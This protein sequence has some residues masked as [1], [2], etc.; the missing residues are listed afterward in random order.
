MMGIVV[1][2]C[3]WNVKFYEENEVDELEIVVTH[4]YICSNC[5]ERYTTADIMYL[6]PVDSG[7]LD[8]ELDYLDIIRKGWR[9]ERMRPGEMSMWRYS[10]LLPVEGSFKSHGILGSIGGT[11]LVYVSK[12]NSNIGERVW[13]K[14]DS[15]LP[16]GSL[17]DRA[18]AVVVSDAIKRGVD[19]IMTASTGNAGVALA[20]MAAAGGLS[21]V[22][23]VPAD[24][25]ASKIAQIVAYGA[26][27]VL[28]EGSYSDAYDVA[29][30]ASNELGIYCRN[31]G[32]NPFTIEGKKT[33]A[34]EICEQLS[35]I[36]ESSGEAIWKV[37]DVVIVPVG[38]GNIISGVYKGF[39]DLLAIGMVSRMPKIF[40]VQAE[41]SAAIANTYNSGD[42]VI[43]EVESNTI[44]D[45][46][47]ADRPA[48]GYRAINAVR[49]T[50]GQY[51]A[52]NDDA[53][54]M[55]VLELSSATGVFA[56]PSA[57]VSFAGLRLMQRCEWINPGDNVVM[58]ITG[59]GLKTV[60][61]CHVDTEGLSRIKPNLLELTD[62][63]KDK[64]IIA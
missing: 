53:I 6:C 64:N 45:S 23:L 58:L 57:A 41:G 48:D 35:D 27:I 24:A 16:T 52:V 46:I 9:P 18:S 1:R 34:Y 3:Q 50:G 49:N 44:A 10:M 4:T 47:S 13:I 33:V 25:P 5:G 59:H 37:P 20:G 29:V 7:V 19:A 38:D 61:A 42:T 39:S 26:E 32:Y 36:L 40:G 43:A 31:T 28:V 17:K 54:E 15:L 12:L 14:N 21:A 56:E 55:A 63:L 62:I 11:P 8:I 22:V 2:T 51:L 60:V 30:Q